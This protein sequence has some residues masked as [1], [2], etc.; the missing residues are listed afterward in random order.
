MPSSRKAV[1]SAGERLFARMRGACEMAS[2][3]ARWLF[4]ASARL[5]TTMP[6]GSACFDDNVLSYRPLTQTNRFASGSAKRNSASS[7]RSTRFVG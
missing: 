7:E 4:I 3:S 2:T 1:L 5:Q 6:S